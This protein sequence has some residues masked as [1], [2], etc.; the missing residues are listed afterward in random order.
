MKFL[1]MFDL[2]ENATQAKVAEAVSRRIEYKFPEG[3]K[4]LAEYW[5]PVASPTVIAVIESSDPAPLLLNSLAWLDVFECKVIPIIDW[6]E[7]AR[8]LGKAFTQR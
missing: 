7:G 5:T 3:T 4:L 1:A 8:K 6:E 2:K